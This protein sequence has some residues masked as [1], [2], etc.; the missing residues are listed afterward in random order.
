[1]RFA[2]IIL[3]KLPLSPLR[4]SSL[5]QRENVDFPRLMRKRGGRKRPGLILRDVH[6]ILLA[7]RLNRARAGIKTK[8]ACNRISKVYPRRIRNAISV[9]VPHRISSAKRQRCLHRIMAGRA[10]L[11]RESV[12]V[13]RDRDF[14]IRIR[15]LMI[16]SQICCNLYI[17]KIPRKRKMFLHIRC[18]CNL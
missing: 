3:G 6:S 17:W 4:S 13:N 11:A 15:I 16:K 5:Y 9:I 18:K 12:R 2:G 10:R 7:L 14:L 1:M 8:F